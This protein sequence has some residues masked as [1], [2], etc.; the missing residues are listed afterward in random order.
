MNV[1]PERGN[2]CILPSLVLFSHLFTAENH[3]TPHSPHNQCDVPACGSSKSAILV[4]VFHTQR[5]DTSKTHTTSGVRERF[6]SPRRNHAQSWPSFLS[7]LGK[8]RPFLVFFLSSI[9]LVC[10]ANARHT[11]TCVRQRTMVR[12]ECGFISLKRKR[13]WATGVL[14]VRPNEEEGLTGTLRQRHAIWFVVQWE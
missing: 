13:L 2:G 9:A 10:Y 12:I 1:N 3:V 4:V 11:Y 8:D 7:H 14:H 6:N 5:A